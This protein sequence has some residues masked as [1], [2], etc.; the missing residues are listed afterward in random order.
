MTNDNSNKGTKTA[1]TLTGNGGD[2]GLRRMAGATLLT[3]PVLLFGAMVTTPPQDDSSLPSYLSSLARDWDRSIL[4]ANL[5]HYYW[6]ALAIA[7]PA[8]LTLLRGDRGRTLASIGVA[9]TV[10]GAIQMSGLIFAD[11]FNAAGPIVAGLD[12]A[13]AI[14]ERVNAD[15]SMAIW[16]N[17][18]KVFGILMPVLAFAGLAR[19]GVIGW[20][21]APV[22]LLPMVGGPIIGSFAGTVV[23]GL[24]G[25]A[26]CA[27]LVMV[28][29]RL[30]SR[31]SPAVAAQE[32]TPAAA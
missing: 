9:G 27:P 11:W 24:A 6:V 16:L 26:C 32:K 2:N 20:W 25:A 4:S 30:L 13:V 5:Y 29:L 15:P 17:S 8:L 14:T 10:L 21:A 12:Q 22:A 1:D 23:G 31:T 18:A 7:L 19:N 28:A 3:A